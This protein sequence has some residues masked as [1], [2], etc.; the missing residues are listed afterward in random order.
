MDNLDYFSIQLRT[1]NHLTIERFLVSK[2]NDKFCSRFCESSVDKRIFIRL[3]GMVIFVIKIV[4]VANLGR[5]L[6]NKMKLCSVFSNLIMTT[7]VP[8]VHNTHIHTYRLTH[9]KKKKKKNR[10][11]SKGR[12]LRDLFKVWIL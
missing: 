4:P 12:D 10:L 2:F 5:I 6:R 7:A 11:K 9:T 1:S 8:R 3:I